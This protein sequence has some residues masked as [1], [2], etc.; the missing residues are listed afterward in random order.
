[1]LVKGAAVLV[2]V[3]VV[4]LEEA[5]A[6]GAPGSGRLLVAN[7]GDHTLGIIDPAAG[8]M[9]A[10]VK[11]SGVTGHEVAASPDGRTA[12]VPI[13]G[14]SGV[15]RPGSDG[16]TMDVI[17]IGARRRVATV[18]FGGPQ[19][20]HG[21]VFGPDGRLYV[22]AELTSSIQV[23]DPRTNAV[24]D[25]I[26]T[27]QPE[28]H[29]LVLSRDGRRAWTSNVGAGTV[30][31]IDLAAR[32]VAAVIHVA[33]L[34]QRIALSTD[35]RWLFTADQEA[36]RLAV[37]DASTGKLAQGVALPGVAYGTAPTPD[38][39]WLLMTL[40]GLNQLGVLDLKS[41]EVAR[42]LDVPKAPQE[43]LVRPDGRVAYVSCD[44]SGQVAEID[45]AEWKVAR[46]IPAGP[47]ADGLA[48]AP[49]P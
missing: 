47:M 29:M 48:W 11:Q 15:G 1:M 38:G 12:Y 36:P 23:V 22:T 32:R 19:R 13:Y 21:A 4:V 9:V 7:K 46:L 39:R 6:A 5:R 45:L 18:D 16:R 2:A 49:Q 41:M 14:D 30:S 40:P 27:G 28:S 3:A 17:D 42:T 35:E 34:A 8:R 20:P 26:P 33:R 44:A 37:V 25:T 24:V 43:V 10:T 31:A